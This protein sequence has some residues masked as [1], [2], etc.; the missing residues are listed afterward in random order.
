MHKSIYLYISFFC[1]LS[2][3]LVHGR[4]FF[5]LFLFLLKTWQTVKQI[6]SAQ[7]YETEKDYEV[8]LRYKA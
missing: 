2:S 7:Q 8:M 3:I 6:C 4:V 5:F 1:I